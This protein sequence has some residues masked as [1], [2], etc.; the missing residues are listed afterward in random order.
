MFIGDQQQ[1]DALTEAGPF[2]FMSNSFS[3]R[4]LAATSAGASDPLVARLSAATTTV[5]KLPDPK[6]QPF[7]S[8]LSF[9]ISNDLVS[10]GNWFC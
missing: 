6:Y 2:D 1:V 4:L 5:P 8:K 3:L 9:L 7:N 10:F